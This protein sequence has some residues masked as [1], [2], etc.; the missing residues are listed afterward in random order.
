MLAIT[1]SRSSSSPGVESNQSNVICLDI[2]YVS[3]DSLTGKGTRSDN[4]EFN[5]CTVTLTSVCIDHL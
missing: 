5:I 4:V 3:S 2:Y 1:S